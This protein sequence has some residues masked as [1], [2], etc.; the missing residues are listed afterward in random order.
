MVTAILA[1]QAL[2]APG[3]VAPEDTLETLG[4]DSM[5]M[6]EAVFAIEEA[7]DI[8]VPFDPQAD[9]GPGFDTGS[10]ARIIAAVQALV[11]ARA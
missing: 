9:D 3:A 7:F 1:R 6:V 2:R 10:V 8:A 11:A 4:I 5:G